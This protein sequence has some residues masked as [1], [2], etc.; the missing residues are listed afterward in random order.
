V[1]VPP[2]RRPRWSIVLPAFDEEHRLPAY[3]EG[4]LGYFQGSGETHEVIVVDD[5]SRD[6]TARSV[7]AMAKEREGL[8]LI[9]LGANRG[10]GYAVRTGMLAATGA[11]RLMADADGATPIEEV[12]RL[13][14]A[15]EAGA[16]IALGSRARPDPAVAV[17]ARTHRKVF[18]RVF[19]LFV[20]G[21]GVHELSDTQ[22]G[23]KL[24]R[25][26]V[27]DAL[28][29]R[30]ATEGFGFDVELVLLAQRAGYRLSEVPVN[31]IDRPGSKVGVLTHGPRMVAEV[32]RARRRLA[33]LGREENAP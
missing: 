28:F 33:A 8:T 2:A 27:A 5:G 16:D 26:H 14:V 23:F 13:E 4:V 19:H 12:K 9:S 20:R 30:V 6:G 22:C 24:F 15:I 21:L 18:G 31:W 29:R 3:L 32:L 25:G 17:V 1:T 10:K 11:L 7:Q